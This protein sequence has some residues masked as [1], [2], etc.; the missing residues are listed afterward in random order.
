MTTHLAE[1][2]IWTSFNPKHLGL[3]KNYRIKYFLDLE[4]TFYHPF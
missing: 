1:N 2:K 3:D 4:N